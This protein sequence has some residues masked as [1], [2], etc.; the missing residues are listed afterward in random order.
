MLYLRNTNQLQS[1]DRGIQRGPADVPQPPQ[2]PITASYFN[3][4]GRTQYQ[5]AF[6]A[7]G[8]PAM[9]PASFTGSQYQIGTAVV[10]SGSLQPSFLTSGSILTG[11]AQ[12]LGYFLPSTTETYS[13]FLSNDDTSYWWVG[14]AATASLPLTASALLAV[15]SSGANATGS[16]ALT[17]GNYVPVRIQY[18]AVANPDFFT[19]SF[20]T[21]TIT[22]TTNF[23]NYTFCNTASLGF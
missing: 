19:A 14:N 13:F 17:S 5:P 7:Q 2:P 23:T 4:L 15:T 16:I 22:K 18:T 21:P 3:G 10:D 6:G 11:S 9:I 20:S 8:A 12:W 1:L